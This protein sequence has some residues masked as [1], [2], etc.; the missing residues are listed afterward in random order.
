VLREGEL[1]ER[2]PTLGT[3]VL[4]VVC[5]LSAVVSLPQPQRSALGAQQSSG[6]VLADTFWSQALGIRKRFLV[7]LPPSYDREPARR[8]PVVYYLHGAFGDE[9]NWTRLGKLD[10]TLDSLTASGMPEL[11][12]IMPDG[13][14]GWY[15]TWNFLG[16]WAGCR[17]AHT[18]A[19]NEPAESYCVP[20]PHYDDYIAR[21]LVAYV[22][23]TFRTRAER[24]YRGIAG[25]SMGG[26]GAV[27]LALSYP[28]VFSAAASHSGVLAPLVGAGAGAGEPLRYAT[29]LDSARTRYGTQLW[30]IMVPAFGKDTA[31]WWSRDPARKASRLRRE[32]PTLAPKLMIDCGTAD[33]FLPQ[34]R[35]LRAEL[36][37]LGWDVAYAEWPGG[38]AWDYWRRHAAESARWLAR[39]LTPG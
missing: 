23:R 21:D 27:T 8:Y 36:E 7:W 3:G 26:Y 2:F 17:R 33:P 20:W 14:D 5:C 38:H 4:S 16:D 35:A 19:G 28:D 30:A 37:K 15:T 9:T 12:V 25:L 34:T 11:I 24:G 13:D 31:A 29:D 18:G 1:A 22:D 39:E 32:R 6:A 10:S